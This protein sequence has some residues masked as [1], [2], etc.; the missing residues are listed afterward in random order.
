MVR[1][2]GAD[3][4]LSVS[5]L[6]VIEDAANRLRH[7]AVAKRALK[8][9]GVLYAFVWSGCYPERGT[10]RKQVDTARGCVQLNVWAAALLPEV[11][12]VFGVGEAFVDANANLIV[13]VNR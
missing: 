3:V 7:L 11:E 12:A 2:G 5:V 6:N 8:P 1:S 10:G 4:V 9:G 13:A